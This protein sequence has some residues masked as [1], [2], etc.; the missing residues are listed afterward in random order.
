VFG[1]ENCGPSKSAKHLEHIKKPDPDILNTYS[2]LNG[3]IIMHSTRSIQ[4]ES[5][6]CHAML[7]LNS[8]V[9]NV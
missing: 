6:V 3:V 2:A 8:S 9:I 4:A 5:A 7:C 1:T